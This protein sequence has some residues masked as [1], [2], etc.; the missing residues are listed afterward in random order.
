MYHVFCSSLQAKQTFNSITENNLE[1]EKVP[2]KLS[3]DLSDLR[4]KTESTMKVLQDISVVMNPIVV[5][6][7]LT[8][9]VEQLNRTLHAL[10]IELYNE[11]V[12]QAKRGS[13]VMGNQQNLPLGVSATS[14]VRMK[15]SACRKGTRN[16]EHTGEVVLSETDQWSE[17]LSS[18]GTGHLIGQS[19]DST[20][21]RGQSNQT[22]G[23]SDKVKGHLEDT[24]GVNKDELSWS[25]VD[26]DSGVFHE[27]LAA[28]VSDGIRGDDPF[29]MPE[30]L[31]HDVAHLAQTCFAAGCYG[32][33]SMYVKPAAVQDSNM[34]TERVTV[35]S[36][37]D[38]Q[39]GDIEWKIDDDSS[40]HL[41]D[42]Y[43]QNSIPCKIPQHSEPDGQRLCDK[44]DDQYR[45]RC[46]VKGTRDQADQRSSSST[47][48][49]TDVCTFMQCYCFL[50][51]MGRVR[52]HMTSYHGNLFRFWC[53]YVKC[54]QGKQ[55]IIFSSLLQKFQ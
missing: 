18:V 21:L 12:R 8:Q 6:D 2:E 41:F 55:K 34:A 16:S 7:V 47:S 1:V 54:V 17:T 11:N 19:V 42:Q 23:Q 53:T 31:Y 14:D 9:W 51:D 22:E 40:T 39:T 45:S 52:E 13:F 50:L 27:D 5:K 24:K 46:P 37:F 38:G 33:V 29:N 4:D 30:D 44:V 25:S 26:L 43:E 20:K 28:Q 36:K 15:D 48:D 49:D 32:N 3:V 35:V 10:H